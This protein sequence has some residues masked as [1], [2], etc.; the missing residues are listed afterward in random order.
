[1]YTRHLP[2]VRT[3]ACVYILPPPPQIKYKTR[4]HNEQA[5]RSKVKAAKAK[6][7]AAT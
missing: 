5:K 3:H 4:K 6:K 2:H 7:A 1:M